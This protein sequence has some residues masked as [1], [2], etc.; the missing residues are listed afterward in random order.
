MG[1]LLSRKLGYWDNSEG[2][3][4][5]PDEIMQCTGYIEFPG[6][7]SASARTGSS[8]MLLYPNP[9]DAEVRVAL[10]PE[11]QGRG[12]LQLQLINLQGQVVRQQTLSTPRSVVLSVS[13]LSPGPY[14]V[15]L[16]AEGLVTTQRL[17]VE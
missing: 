4:G 14:V 9:S 5:G 12:A 17:V 10:A 13:E 15:K 3:C 16:S 6:T 8:S 7:G 11:L 1:N 2:G